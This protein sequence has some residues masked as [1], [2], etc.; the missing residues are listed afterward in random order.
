[1]KQMWRAAVA[2]CVLAGASMAQAQDYMPSFSN[3]NLSAD[4]ANTI[5]N[6]TLMEAQMGIDRE[7]SERAGPSDPAM[8]ARASRAGAYATTYQA[9]AAVT[10]RVK[11]QFADFVRSTGGDG[12]GIAAAMNDQD[13]FA[14]WGGHV[15]Q[16]GLRRGDVADAMTA[17]WV[18]NWQIANDVRSVDR[19]QVQAVKAQVRQNM[20]SN[21][22]FGALNIAQKQEMAE[23]LILNFIV[24]SVAYEDA[25]RANDATMQRRLQNAATTRFRNEMNVDLRQLRLGGSGFT[26]AS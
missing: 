20:T 24:Q 19:S 7:R 13:F 16:Y 4:I 23:A 22:Q 1:M 17:Y 21:A 5:M 2:A 9:S 12:A 6:N 11:R 26:A 18:L 8:R 3:G 14:R 15:S 10:E 25:M